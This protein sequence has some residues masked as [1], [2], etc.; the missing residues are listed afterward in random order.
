MKHTFIILLKNK[1][2]DLSRFFGVIR[3]LNFKIE[4]LTIKKT[5]DS[6]IYQIILIINEKSNNTIEYLTR[7][8]NQ[9]ISIVKITHVK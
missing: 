3:R 8:L 1:G 4:E 2:E 5:E 7:K 6:E 9:S